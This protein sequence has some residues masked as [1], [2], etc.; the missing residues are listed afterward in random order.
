MEDFSLDQMLTN[1]QRGMVDYLRRKTGVIEKEEQEAREFLIG[2]CRLYL[3]AFYNRVQMEGGVIFTEAF[4]SELRTAMEMQGW[5][6]EIHPDNLNLD[7]LSLSEVRQAYRLILEVGK[8]VL[9]GL[10]GPMG[11]DTLMSQVGAG[12]SPEV[13]KT[14]QHLIENRE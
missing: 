12:L 10:I 6:V 4:L 2:L 9:G 8:R 13:A 7:G 11:V 3:M 1:E 5:H 14:V